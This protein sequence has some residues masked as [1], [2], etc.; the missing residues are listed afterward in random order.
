MA[1]TKYPTLEE[2]FELHRALIERFGGTPGVR[3]AGGLESALFRPKTG[4][5]ESLATE[6]A[7]LMQSLAMN[8]PFVDGN[9]RVAFALTAVFLRMNGYRIAST[10]DDAENFIIDRVIGGRASL[11]EIERWLTAHMR[12]LAR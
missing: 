8:H 11:D 1:T 2:A 5:Y 6:A 4:Y 10:A 7:A 12:A 3:D 9:K